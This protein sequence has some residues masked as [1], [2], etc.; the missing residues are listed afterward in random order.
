MVH[1]AVQGQ[2][3]CHVL[4]VPNQ[5][6][7]ENAVQQVQAQLHEAGHSIT[8]GQVEAALARLLCACSLQDLGVRPRDLESIKVR[9]DFSMSLVR[10]QHLA[11]KA[12]ALVMHPDCSWLHR[13]THAGNWGMCAGAGCEQKG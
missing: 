2:H 8:V 12:F 10:R 3:V 7:L 4:P 5:Q 9:Y 1:K 13:S 11:V 6:Q